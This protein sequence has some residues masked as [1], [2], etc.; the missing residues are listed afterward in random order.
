[1]HH[2]K[3]ALCVTLAVPEDSTL[4]CFT[5]RP[6]RYFILRC[7]V[8]RTHSNKILPIPPHPHTL[9]KVLMYFTL[10]KINCQAFKRKTYRFFSVGLYFMLTFRLFPLNN[11]QT[12]SRLRCFH[13]HQQQPFF[14]FQ[15]KYLKPR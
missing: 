9:L 12:V 1:M 3:D 4:P 11:R 10:K 6:Q 8:H 5:F 13:Y 7:I 2:Y 14:R 15:C